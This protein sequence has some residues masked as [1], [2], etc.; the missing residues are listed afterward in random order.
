MRI[1]IAK[2][3]SLK[4]NRDE[5]KIQ[6]LLNKEV[7]KEWDYSDLSLYRLKGSAYKMKETITTKYFKEA[8]STQVGGFDNLRHLFLWCKDD[9]NW[10][11][12]KSISILF[13]DNNNRFV[14]I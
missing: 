12:K 4:T 8:Q 11:Y 9:T 14:E 10:E 5:T 3:L 6:L 2:G 13:D 7:V 1:N